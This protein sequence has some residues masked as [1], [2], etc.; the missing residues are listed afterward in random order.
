MNSDLEATYRCDPAAVAP[1]RRWAYQALSQRVGAKDAVDDAVLVVS[2]LVTNAVRAESSQVLVHLEVESNAILVGVLDDAAGSP[3][4][5]DV[6]ATA[7]AGRGLNIVAAVARQW[8]VRPRRADG[9][10]G[11]EVWARIALDARTPRLS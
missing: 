3:R 11:K 2:E 7:P 6:A 9:L 8:G 1:A 5:Q 10:A 4:Q